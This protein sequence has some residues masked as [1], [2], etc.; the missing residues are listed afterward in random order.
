MAS[1][2]D[3]LVRNGRVIDPQTGFNRVCDVAIAGGRITAIGA[4]PGKS[5]REIDATGLV[6][7]PGFIDLHAHGQSLPADR[8]QAF[9]GV[10]TSLELEAGA[11]PVSAWYAHQE[12]TGR[13]LNY[14]CSANWITARIAV[15]NQ[16]APEF[17]LAFM[18]RHANERRWADD[19]ATDAEVA[20][21]LDHIRRG[22]DE[23]ALGIGLLN[24]YAPG[25]GV[26]EMTEV[27]ALAAQYAVPTYTHIAYMSN[28]D[29]RSSIEAYTRLIGY[30]A[31]TGAHMHICHF[32][33]TSV[34]DV[35]RA[36]QLVQHAQKMGLKVTVEA[37]PYGTGSTLLSA[38][39]FRDPDF[40]R[41]SGTDWSALQMVDTGR[42]F[43]KHDEVLR[44]QA[45]DPAALVL[46]HFLDVE[47]NQRHR[48]LLDV[49]VLF[50]GG[51][52]ASDAMPWTRP[53][54]SIYDADAWPL[55]DGTSSHPRSA[56]TFTRF[57][58]RW[59]RERKTMTLTEGL[60]K[61][62]LIPAQIMEASAPQFAKKGRLQ[63]GCDADIVVFDWD[64]LV[65]R[66][67][68][69][70]MNRTADGVRH[71]LVNGEAVIAD[72]VLQTAARPGRPLRRA[73]KV[74]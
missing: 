57:L 66:A 53:D 1:E 62:T 29:P 74:R 73:S 43:Q 58:A 27:C 63:V 50:P 34:M 22:L 40:A 21:I 7:A 59:V 33:S 23:G 70:A 47:A 14:G 26:K 18:A 61:C 60:A 8:M 71:L 17:T 72:G 56:G 64:K 55:P 25:S 11:L 31:S 51:A 20:G 42:R 30:A 32:N 41:R 13:T 5:A 37:Y 68:F 36:A 4:A 15:M 45:Q 49:S 19:V 46:W 67:D 52:I 38:T 2:H 3:L 39:F 9:D 69:K 12:A 35:E 48:D 44:A 28:V 24:A 6:V 16:A 65:D 10:T 54:G